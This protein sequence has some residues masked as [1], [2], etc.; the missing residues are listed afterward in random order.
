MKVA[1][2][3]V[4]CVCVSESQGIRWKGDQEKW[5][6]AVNQATSPIYIYSCVTL[7]RNK[8]LIVRERETAAQT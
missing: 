6:I 2:A 3:S 7:R 8:V 4:V 1:T 5:P